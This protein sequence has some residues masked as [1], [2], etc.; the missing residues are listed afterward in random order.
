MSGIV[1]SCTLLVTTLGGN[2]PCYHPSNDEESQNTVRLS[3]LSQDPQLVNDKTKVQR[4]EVA[5]PMTEPR[6]KL[7][8][9]LTAAWAFDP[10]LGSSYQLS[11]V[12]Q[13]FM[14][15]EALHT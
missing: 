7:R 13:H 11:A 12:T 9:P 1:L 3:N 4:S 10:E 14:V 5:F 2:Y 15:T 6:C 8:Q